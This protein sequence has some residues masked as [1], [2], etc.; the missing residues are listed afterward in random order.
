MS[1]GE[2]QNNEK[3]SDRK[4][5]VSGFLPKDPLRLSKMSFKMSHQAIRSS[6][7]TELSYYLMNLPVSAGCR[8]SQSLFCPPCFPPT[9]ETLPGT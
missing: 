1:F 9:S 5:Q 8:Y 6:V 2:T 4:L 3:P 7:F